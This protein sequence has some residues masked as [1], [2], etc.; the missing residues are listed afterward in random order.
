MKFSVSGIVEIPN[1]KRNFTREVEAKSERHAKEKVFAEFGSANGVNRNK[2]K[3][4]SVSK[5]G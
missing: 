2:V 3:I 1:G 5:V 4:E